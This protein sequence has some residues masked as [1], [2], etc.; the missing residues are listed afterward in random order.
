MSTP[1]T[2]SPP[3]AQVDWNNGG[4]G[5]NWSYNPSGYTNS[6]GYHNSMSQDTQWPGWQNQNQYYNSNMW[7]NNNTSTPWE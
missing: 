7:P 6:G 3:M 5:Y 1:I 4:Y 2:P